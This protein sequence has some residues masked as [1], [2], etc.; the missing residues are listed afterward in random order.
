[1]PQNTLPAYTIDLRSDTVT[2][3]S[4][5]MR[6]AIAA[7][8]VGDDVYGED[9]S[10]NE[11]ESEAAKILGKETAVFFPT[12]TQSN[13]CAILSHCQRGDEMLVGK[14]YHTFQSEAGGASALGGVAFSTLP[15]QRDGGINPEDVDA[16]VRPNDDLHCAKTKLF[17]IENT[18]LGRAVPLESLRPAVDVARQHGLRVHL[19]GA[20]IFNASIELTEDVKAIANLA[21]TV[22]VCLSKGLGAPAGTI[23]ATSSE[24]EP[25]IRRNRKMLGGGMRQI[26]IVAAAGLYALRNNVERLAEDHQRAENLAKELLSIPAKCNLKVTQATNI[27]YIQPKPEDHSKLHEFLKSQK[28]LIGKKRPAMRIVTNLGISNNDISRVAKAIQQFYE[29]S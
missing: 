7:S 21:D 4:I 13:L 14:S 3:P 12:G 26:G 1:M 20:R 18:S 5:E 25:I 29:E 10:V 23:L 15:V 19:D 17:C 9:P 11:L 16:S 8:E 24:M 6:K 27:V 2:L 22:S 28:I